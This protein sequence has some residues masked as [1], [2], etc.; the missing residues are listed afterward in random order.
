MLMNEILKTKF[1]GL[2]SDASAVTNEEMQRAYEDFVTQV[3]TLNSSE[4]DYE[5]SF[6]RLNLTRIELDSLGSA[7]LYGQRKKCPEISLSSKSFILCQF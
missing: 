2:L 3:E 4:P 6:R 1:V 5:K 7:P